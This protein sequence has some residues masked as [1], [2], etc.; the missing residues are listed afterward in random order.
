MK[1]IDKVARRRNSQ[2]KAAPF[3]RRRFAFQIVLIIDRR[4]GAVR[5]NR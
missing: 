4:N 2:S 1:D 5:K 3:S